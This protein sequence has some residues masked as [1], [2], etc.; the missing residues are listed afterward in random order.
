MR[1]RIAFVLTVVALSAATAGCDWTMYRYGPS[2]SGDN[3]FERTI[4]TANVNQLKTR[5]I[6]TT[7]GDRA[8][9]AHR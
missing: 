5:W 1:L 2:H 9:Q 3:P 8:A 6:A 4:G 7:G